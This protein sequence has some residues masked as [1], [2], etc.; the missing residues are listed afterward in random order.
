[1]HIM[2]AEF[3]ED[4][5]RGG[6]HHPNSMLHASPL[7]RCHPIHD[8]LVLLLSTVVLVSCNPCCRVCADKFGST[9]Q[10]HTPDTYVS[11]TTT[12]EKH[13]NQHHNHMSSTR[14]FSRPFIRLSLDRTTRH[15]T[16]CHN[17]ELAEHLV[18]VMPSSQFPSPVL[19]V[20]H[21]CVSVSVAREQH[22]MGLFFSFSKPSG[23]ILEPA[24]Q[25]AIT[26]VD[27]HFTT[28]NTNNTQKQETQHST[29]QQHSHQI[30]N[31]HPSD[32]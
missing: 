9:H 11:T 17:S 12:H 8:V 2:R 23:M 13:L 14:R 5:T 30:I 27:L 15:A 19:H 29:P 21:C 1:M 20:A 16:R 10:Q 28:S 6:D 26:T 32:L 7:R 24:T 22:T 4:G 18:Q 3:M 25:A 31:S